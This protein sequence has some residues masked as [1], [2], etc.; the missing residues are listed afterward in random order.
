MF[1]QARLEDLTAFRFGHAHNAQAAT[2]C[3]II[4]APQG[5]ACGVDVRGGGPATRETDLLKPENMIEAVHAVV[6][7][8]GSAFGL[9]ASSGVMDALAE[10]GIGFA[11]ECAR[12]PIV[13]GACLFDLLVGEQ[14]H[15]DKAMGRAA[16]EA[17][18]AGEPL[19]QGNVGAGTGATVGKLLG[20]ERAMKSGFGYHVMRFGELVVGALVAVN[21]LGNVR[22]ED[23]TWIAGCRADDGSVMD[24]GVA[25]EVAA[26]AMTAQTAAASAE[27]PCPNT[28]IGVVVTNAR[29]SKAQATK[30]SS[31]CHDAYARAI[32][33]VH[34]SNDGDTVFSFASGEIEAPADLVA[35]MG[36]EAMQQAIYAAV[37]SAEP[38]Y[39][40]P[41]MGEE[42]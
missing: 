30:V 37:S 42:A 13:V 16:V 41:A 31:T 29:L 7:S 39:G 22:D 38:A 35:A 26:R 11:V 28:T 36:T 32:K 12:V 27:Q 2:G 34:T 1:E 10:R 5:A 19:S 9:E 18:F 24:G 4:I 8:G 20:G 33:P 14:A 15:P 17:A 25:F 40:Y 6:L 3:T 21:A 23:G